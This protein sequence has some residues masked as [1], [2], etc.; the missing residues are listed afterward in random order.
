M[1]RS[2]KEAIL[3]NHAK[4]QKTLYM[5]EEPM[6]HCPSWAANVNSRTHV[7]TFSHNGAK[8]S[9]SEISKEYFHKLK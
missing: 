7:L 6:R 9:R 4:L 8:D 5:G 2:A 1:V 3:E